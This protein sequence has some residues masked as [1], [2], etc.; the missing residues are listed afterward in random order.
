MTN[1]SEL[2]PFLNETLYNQLNNGA[3]QFSNDDNDDNESPHTNLSTDEW[4]M[5]AQTETPQKPHR[6]VADVPADSSLAPPS[7]KKRKV[8]LIQ[9]EWVA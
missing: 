3:L 8:S 5:D 2:F 1:I 7:F 6:E 4:R 9:D